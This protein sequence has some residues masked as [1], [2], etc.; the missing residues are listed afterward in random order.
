MVVMAT[1]N[2]LGLLLTLTPRTEAPPLN[3]VSH[4]RTLIPSKQKFKLLIH[5]LTVLM[6]LLLLEQKLILP[7]PAILVIKRRSL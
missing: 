3:V 1:K 6:F 4:P 7:H 2:Q 5:L